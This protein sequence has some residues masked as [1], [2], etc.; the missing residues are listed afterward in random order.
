MIRAIDAVTGERTVNTTGPRR[1]VPVATAPSVT[2]LSGSATTSMLLPRGARRR[3]PIAAFSGG[4]AALTVLIVVLVMRRGDEVP[5]LAPRATEAAASPAAPTPSNAPPSPAPATAS[6]PAG[7][8]VTPPGAPA[9]PAPAAGDSP[10]PSAPPATAA[11]SAPAAPAAPEDRAAPTAPAPPTAE[12]AHAEPGA[13]PDSVHTADT[14]AIAIESAP[15]GAQVVL[16]NEPVGTTPYR[17]TVARRDR[18][19][20]LVVRL[21]G[22]ADRIVIVRESQPIIERVTLVRK[23][24]AAPAKPKTDRD[25][26]V[27]PF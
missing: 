16:D 22:Y 19:G 10:A 14:V 8:A 5:A 2:T 6:P 9:V 1:A 17:G 13:A 25:R 20:K 15:P 23:A 21:S 3:W 18:E 7:A 26:S 4:L 11:P 24:A 27:N 12:P